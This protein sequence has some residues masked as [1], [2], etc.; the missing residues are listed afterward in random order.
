MAR[1]RGRRP[2]SEGT[3]ERIGVS[4]RAEFA[5]R[6]Y[7]A[8]TLRGIARRAEVDPALLHHY[9]NGKAGLFAEA[10]RFRSTAGRS[11]RPSVT[12]LRRSWDSASYGR[13]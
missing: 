8:A 13:F 5:E 1:P 2:A 11:S 9:F 12:D 3:R 10:S 6:G 4:A 7:D